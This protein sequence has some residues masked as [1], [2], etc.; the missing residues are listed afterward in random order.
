MKA[1]RK[2]IHAFNS[3]KVGQKTILTGSAETYPYQFINQYNINNEPKKL[4]VVKSKGKVYAE[5]II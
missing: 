3:L 5:R 4:K 1:G 2:P